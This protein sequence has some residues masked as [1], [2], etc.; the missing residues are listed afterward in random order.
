MTV[1][2]I[3]NT[4]A[5]MEDPVSHQLLTEAVYL[6]P[7]GHIVNEETAL[8]WMNKGGMCALDQ[9]AIVSFWQE[10]T[11]RVRAQEWKEPQ[12]VAYLAFPHFERG[13]QLYASR[14]YPEAAAAFRMAFSFQPKHENARKYLK[15]CHSA[16][17][18][19]VTDLEKLKEKAG[20]GDVEALF[21]LGM[22][23]RN[24]D[25]GV[26]QSYITAVSYFKEAAQKGHIDAL[27]LLGDMHYRGQGTEKSAAEALKC[28]Q[29][30]ERKGNNY[31]RTALL[32]VGL[33]CGG[34]I[35]L[36]SSP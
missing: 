4:S 21:G 3:Y 7:C 31:A 16:Q 9:G 22:V 36:H 10:H 15:L 26:A 32:R 1:S 20:Q 33:K 14:F 2:R 12:A 35:D 13:K 29:E 11:V 25:E 17:F 18:S 28:Y 8:E 27:C 24:G 6:S 34:V 19:Q 30:A 23:Y 5:E